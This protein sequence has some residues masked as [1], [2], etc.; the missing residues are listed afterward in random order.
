MGREGDDRLYG[1]EGND[2][3]VFAKGHGQDFI[4]DDDGKADTIQFLD[5]SFDE[6]KL[7]KNNK[8]LI[9]YDYN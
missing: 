9:I 2:I 5:V 6:V 8:D 1:G 3:Y 4:Y 7:R